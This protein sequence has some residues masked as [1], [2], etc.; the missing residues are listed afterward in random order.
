MNFCIKCGSELMKG[1]LFCGNCGYK[2]PDEKLNQ[3]VSD[4]P[5]DSE[6]N[7]SETVSVNE[8]LLQDDD[9]VMDHMPDIEETTEKEEREVSLSAEESDDTVDLEVLSNPE[10]E[11][12]IDIPKSFRHG[13]KLL[14]ALIGIAVAFIMITGAFLG[15]IISNDQ[16]SPKRTAQKYVHSVIDGDSDEIIELMYPKKVLRAILKKQNMSFDTFEEIYEDRY[17]LIERSY[18]RDYGKNL[19]GKVRITDKV[20]LSK[21]DISYKEIQIKRD[22]NADINIT[23]ACMIECEITIMGS[24]GQRTTVDSLT[25]Y[26]IGRKWYILR[27]A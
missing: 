15:L 7:E 1:A 27:E 5:A 2:I 16:I 4:M 19:R 18:S 8:T 23:D 11:E 26:K 6:V 25:L 20:K 21:E 14:F 10:A 22:T 12:T 17:D 3:Q 13:K 9:S 24:K